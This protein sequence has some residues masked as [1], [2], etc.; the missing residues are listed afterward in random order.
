MSSSNVFNIED[1]THFDRITV[2]YEDETN[3]IPDEYSNRVS[4]MN[5]IIL[6]NGIFEKRYQSK[7][8]CVYINNKEQVVKVSELQ[9]DTSVFAI[10]IEN[11]LVPFLST[12]DKCVTVDVIKKTFSNVFDVSKFN[13]DILML[14]IMM[15]LNA[16][17]VIVPW[18]IHKIPI[19]IQNL[20]MF[21]NI[22]TYSTDTFDEFIPYTVWATNLL[23]LKDYT[24]RRDIFKLVCSMVENYDTRKVDEIVIFG[25][26][27]YVNEERFR[28]NKEVHVPL[29]CISSTSNAIGTVSVGNMIEYIYS[30]YKSG[31]NV[32]LSRQDCYYGKDANVSYLSN[33]LRNS[34][35]SI[36]PVFIPDIPDPRP[37]I[38]GM[39][40]TAG[41]F[42]SLI[43]IDTNILDKDSLLY[44]LDIYQQQIFSVIMLEFMKKRYSVGNLSSAAN[45]HPYSNIKI[46]F[47]GAECA[48]LPRLMM[49]QLLLSPLKHKHMYKYDHM[50][51]L[52]TINCNKP[53]INDDKMYEVKTMSN[54]TNKQLTRK[55]IT[56]WTFN[57]DDDKTFNKTQ[58]QVMNI[59][60]YILNQYG[61][62][63]NKEHVGQSIWKSPVN[64]FDVMLRRN[65]VWL[66]NNIFVSS[67]L[68]YE[69]NPFDF[70]NTFSTIFVLNKEHAYKDI[71]TYVNKQYYMN[72]SFMKNVMDKKSMN[73]TYVDFKNV[74]FFGTK[75]SKAVIFP[76]EYNDIKF[77]P[78]IIRK[79]N[80]YITE[81]Y[82]SSKDLGDDLFKD[83]DTS[84]KVVEIPDTTDEHEA[85]DYGFIIGNKWIPTLEKMC[86]K[87]RPSIDWQ[88]VESINNITLSQLQNTSY[89]VGTSST[90][91]WMMTAF[92]NASKLRVLE[93]G[94][95]LTY[96]M[97]WYM[98]AATV[99]AKHSILSLKTE[100]NKQCMTRIKAKFED[101]MNELDK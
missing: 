89:I 56:N 100:P 94:D 41:A 52:D 14:C 61:I 23:K 32:F 83:L 11:E 73:I 21:P 39:G 5:S 16:T 10:I 1:N 97:D 49:N 4:F 20:G 77:V 22:H 13:H 18:E 38:L 45:F 72:T 63:N 75:D 80:Q 33:I 43:R 27:E 55:K 17:D 69:N 92:T 67:S 31:T 91:A 87:T 15:L 58:I 64:N 50:L 9:K 74:N 82:I 36:N 59:D 101:Y 48:K 34:I 85:K 78:H 65:Y 12:H 29:K 68:D 93:I 62:Y 28:Y 37:E 8:R 86:K 51:S 46:A 90:D 25:N 24:M 3:H 70:L 6:Q 81:E 57:T 54:M 76:K 2:F 84:S 19:E 40:Q 88:T 26:G 71:I 60:G 96:S 98:L 30:Q 7:R 35:F 95:E 53:I 79:M 66:N 44:K 47:S 99:G 42:T